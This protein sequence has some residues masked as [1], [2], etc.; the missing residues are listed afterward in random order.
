MNTVTL[1]VESRDAVS[2]RFIAAMTGEH[3]GQFITFESVDLLFQ[4]LTLLRWNLISEMTGARP[5]SISELARRLGRE[6]DTVH[7]D[8]HALLD[9]GI[10]ERTD[11][12][13]IEFPYDKVHVDF[14]LSGG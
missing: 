7:D 8:V 10:L 5:L 3:Q 2:E 9:A 1:G 12:G 6:V 11:A 4:T 14:T 13:M